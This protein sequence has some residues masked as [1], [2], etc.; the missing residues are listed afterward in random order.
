[1][2]GSQIIILLIGSLTTAATYWFFFAK[3]EIKASVT[4]SSINIKV[5]AGYS[6]S[7]IVVKKN[8]VFTLK[9]TRTDRSDCLDEIVL[10]E[11]NIKEFL[12]LNK[13]INI[14]INPVKEG[15]YPF[16][17]GMNMFHG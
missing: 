11:W 17:C 12:P 14:T 16:H 8:Q 10:P 13:E 4:G 6:P 1:M 9:I 7:E 2:T 15:Q 5:D 3:K